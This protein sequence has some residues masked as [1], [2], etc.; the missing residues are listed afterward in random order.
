MVGNTPRTTRA[1]RLQAAFA[2][3][4]R[5]PVFHVLHEPATAPC[6]GAVLYVHP[7]A[8]EMNKSR[9]MAALQ[10]RSLAARGYAV[11]MPDLYGCGDS[12]GDFADARWETWVEDL[13]RARDDLLAQ[14]GGPLVL[15][16]LRAGCLLLNELSSDN[17]GLPAAT[18]LWQPVVNGELHLTQFLRLRM[19][20]GMM[21]G[22]KETVA[23]LRGRLN[24]G[25]T[26]EVAGY[27]LAPPLAA[28]LAE[29]TL[30]PP[31]AG[32]L[33]WLE[34]V[35]EENTGLLPASQ[36]VI[37]AWRGGGVQL[38]T[39][40]VPGEPFWTTQEI[41]EAPALLQATL[42]VLRNLG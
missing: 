11:L 27:E 14:Y 33:C 18:V 9:R 35:P 7:F 4:S 41:R 19:A 37:E 40:A 3:G 25:E 2:E 5:G 23:Q 15:W 38:Q 26:L 22:A 34:V 28:R 36:R 12:G 21:G 6:R 42:Q 13:R 30:R 20:A 1:M 24:A 39:L 16:G 32:R 17:A 8:E 10:A 31:A 29:A